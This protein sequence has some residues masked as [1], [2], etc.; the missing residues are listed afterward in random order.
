MAFEHDG[1]NRYKPVAGQVAQSA[2]SDGSLYWQA[3]FIAVLAAAINNATASWKIEESTDGTTYVD[4]TS[5][6]PA[7]FRTAT[8][9]TSTAFH[10]STNS[11]APYVKATLMNNG[12]AATGVTYVVLLGKPASG[13]FLESQISG[14]EDGN[15]AP[16]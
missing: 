11:K 7:I 9:G 13:P 6:A 5:T 4:V 15:M 10:A 14:V 1:F 12:V 3:T 8:S 2:Q 16:Y